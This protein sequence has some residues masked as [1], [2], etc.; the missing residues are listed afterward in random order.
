S[1]MARALMKAEEGDV[2]AVR[3]PQGLDEVEVIRISYDGP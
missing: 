3:T 1:P 2:V